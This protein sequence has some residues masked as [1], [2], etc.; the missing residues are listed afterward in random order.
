M[1]CLV[2]KFH[3]PKAFS[4]AKL[5]NHL[6]LIEKFHSFMVKKHVFWLILTQNHRNKVCIDFNQCIELS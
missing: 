2:F 1:D 6:F 4:T 5:L 3:L